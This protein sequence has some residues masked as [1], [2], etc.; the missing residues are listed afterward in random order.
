[1]FTPSRDE[2]RLFFIEAWQ[3]QRQGTPSTPLE[4]LAAQWIAEHPEYHALLEAGPQ[5]VS[6]EYL[7]E[8]GQAN[9]FLHLSMHLSLSE[10]VSIDQPPG[11]RAAIERLAVRFDSLHEAHHQAMECLGEMLWRSQRDNIPP[12]GATYVECLNRRAS[13]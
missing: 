1:M 11:V 7:P 5:S 3:K 13:V 10:Q 4:T 8:D 12:D 9:P 6:G 2:I